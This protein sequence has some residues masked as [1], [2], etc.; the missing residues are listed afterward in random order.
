[1][2]ARLVIDGKDFTGRTIDSII[3][4]EF[5]PKASLRRYSDSN[6]PGIGQVVV[7]APYGGSLVKG[8]V[9]YAYE[10]TRP[11]KPPSRQQRWDNAC[12]KMRSALD[13]AQEVYDEIQSDQDDPP[14]GK[15]AALLKEDYEKRLDQATGDFAD[16]LSELRDLRDEYQEWYDNLPESL[17][18]S[19]V[20]EKLQEI[21]D[22]Y[23]LDEEAEFTLEEDEVTGIDEAE[24]IVDEAEYADLPRGFGRD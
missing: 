16:G 2:S 13:S 3:R 23:S 6:Q 9:S 21:I 18:D 12:A 1:M 5:G 22:M 24:S 20:A 10:Y 19:P 7:P 8:T 17:Q 11:P 15:E 14:E 4:R